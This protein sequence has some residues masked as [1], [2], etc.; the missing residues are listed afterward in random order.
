V[1]LRV[2]GSAAGGGVPQWNCACANCTDARNGRAPRRTQSSIAVS[3][4]GRTWLLIN[5]SPDVSHQIAG[6]PALWTKELR[7]TP[8]AGAFFTDANVDHVG[9]LA[10][11]R[12]DG[13]HRFVF[14]SSETVRDILHDQRAFERFMKPPHE[15]HAMRAGEEVAIGDLRIRAVSVPGVTPGYAGR[16]AVAGAVFAYVITDPATDGRTL[17]APVFS[18]CDAVLQREIA[19][20]DVSFL[21]GSFFDDAELARE[22]FMA[23]TATHLGHAPIGGANG[24]LSRMPTARARIIFTHVNNTNPILRDGS[25]A[26][27]AIA[28]AGCEI[29]YDTMEIHL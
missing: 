18:Q 27:Q 7:G 15:W 5:V 13:P 14:H 2:L 9:G 26:A 29:A 12:Q 17:L 16:Q 19:D 4:D 6:T 11:L 25:P 10:E 20:A 24:T 23:K 1:I 22:G 28:E 8:I 3:S 21:D